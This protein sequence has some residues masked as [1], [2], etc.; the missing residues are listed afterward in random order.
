MKSKPEKPDMETISWKPEYSTGNSEIDL[1]H[2]YFIKL[3]HRLDEELKSSDDPDHQNRLLWELSK[4]VEFHF[5]SE[6][7]I[8]RKAGSEGLEQMIS[9]HESLSEELGGKI[10]GSM[11]GI[12]P[13]EDVISFLTNW[14]IKHTASEDKKTFIGDK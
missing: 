5:L 10:Q 11:M 3:I 7:N 12:V 1:Q 8:L 13:A 14:F 2:Q 9:S 4:Y 6:E